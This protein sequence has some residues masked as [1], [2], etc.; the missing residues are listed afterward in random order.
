M[1]NENNQATK[2][3]KK[4]KSPFVRLIF[5]KALKQTE[6]ERNI[7]IDMLRYRNNSFS[8]SLGYIA[9]LAQIVAFCFIYSCIGVS[10][11]HNV[12]L[13][14]INHSGLWCGID[15]FVNIAMLLFL[16]LAISRMKVYDKTWGIVSIC[17]GVLQIIRLFLYPFALYTSV[18]T[19]ATETTVVMPGWIF[20]I[21]VVCYILCGVLL[22]ASGVV[23]VILSKILNDYLTSIKASEVKK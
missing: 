7:Q 3:P 16:F 21:Q 13:F 2:T 6:E 19:A 22:I 18:P 15:I 4:I 8:T 11:D 5:S 1:K 23:T 17:L 14:G 9:L 12:T 20:S 10:M